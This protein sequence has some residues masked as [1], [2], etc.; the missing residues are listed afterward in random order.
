MLTDILLAE[1]FEMHAFSWGGENFTE[2]GKVR[3][4]YIRAL[5]AADAGNYS[6]LKRFLN[7]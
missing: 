4:Q 5:R 6:L 7:V 2:A 1:V 3:S